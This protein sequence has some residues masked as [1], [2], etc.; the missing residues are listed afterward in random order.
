M[1]DRFLM[2]DMIQHP[3]LALAINLYV[4]QHEAVVKGICDM[5]D[6]VCQMCSLMFPLMSLLGY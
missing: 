3:N 2:H 4:Q 6:T 1:Y 5:A